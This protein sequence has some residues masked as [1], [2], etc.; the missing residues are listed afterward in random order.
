VGN[1][2]VSEKMFVP[3]RWHHLVAQKNG[4]RMELYFDGVPDL[5]MPLIADHQTVSCNLVIGRRSGEPLD[6]T[7]I[8]PF[9]GRLDE[10]AIYDHP[11]SA[12]EVRSHF[13]LAA[14]NPGPR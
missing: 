9:I 7:D 10:L 11:L 2:I 4:D 1:N 13:R 6:Q 14:P 8:R 3:R 5:S 12:E